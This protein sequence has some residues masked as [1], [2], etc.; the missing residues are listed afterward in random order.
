VKP[1][2][3]EIQSVES[4][5]LAANGGS[6]VRQEFLP[7]TRP[8]IGPEEKQ[9]VM[10]TLDGVWLSRGPKVSQ[11]EEEFQNYTKANHAIAVCSCTAALHVSIVA[12]G[13]KEGDEVIT[14]PIT[15][16]ATT[17][18][19]L[20]ERA[21]PVL[22]DVDRKTFNM[23]PELIEERITPRTKAIIPVH[24]AG[25]PCDMDRILEIARRRHLVV[26]EDA[27]H[28]IGAKYGEKHAGTLGDAG[29]FSF[30]ASK[31][32]V[33]GDGGMIIADDKKF[34][35]FAR[36]ISLHGMSTTAW[37]RYSK[38][39][40]TSWEL[41]YPGFKYNM[42]DIEAS[43]GIHQLRKIELITSLRQ[44]WSA[45]YDRLL[46]DLPEITLPHRA[47]GRRHACHLYV[48]TL[49]VNRLNVTRDQFMAMLKA[50]NI[51]CGIHFVSVH[52]QPYY[53]KRFGYGTGDYPNAAWLS[54]RILSLPLFP[55]MT[56]T[57]VQDVSRAVHKVIASTRRS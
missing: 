41:V 4:A 37:K 51:G 46:A 1:L 42:T 57:D 52:L 36:V 21:T 9:E 16:P 2:K 45:L 43:L 15:F 27:A 10:D 29:C 44:K 23:A 5:E 14:S 55:Q 13:V 31:N 33:T 38:E 20:Y 22:V 56:E 35:E 17:N 6:P 8:W 50:E 3:P 48:I 54:D 34:A 47:P 26:I 30:Y 40:S 28:A 53:Q 49:D 19:I 39:G 12:A 24:M 11:F 18:A 32:L 25:Q 7:L